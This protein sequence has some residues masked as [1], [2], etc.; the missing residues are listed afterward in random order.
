LIQW[1]RRQES[2]ARH[3]GG[4]ARLLVRWLIPKALS[5][6]TMEDAVTGD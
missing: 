6:G 2:N 1:N 5:S 4:V 3:A